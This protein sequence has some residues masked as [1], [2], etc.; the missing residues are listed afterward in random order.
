MT[1]G[2]LIL[3]GLITGEIVALVK[4]GKQNERIRRLEEKVGKQEKK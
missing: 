2:T 4:V 1:L 3:L